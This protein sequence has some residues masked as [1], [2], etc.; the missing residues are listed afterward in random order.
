MENRDS[1][2]QD[3]YL[4]WTEAYIFSMFPICDD[5]SF[6]L[7]ASGDQ[8]EILRAGY[9]PSYNVP[10][11]EEV[12]PTKRRSYNWL[13]FTL[14][15]TVEIICL[16]PRQWLLVCSQAH[17]WLLHL[18]LPLPI[19]HRDTSQGDFKC[20]FKGGMEK[21]GGGGGTVFLNHLCWG[22]RL[23]L[24]LLLYANQ[25]LL[26]V[27][28]LLWIQYVNYMKISHLVY[29]RD[30]SFLISSVNINCFPLTIVLSLA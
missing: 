23:P 16:M 15:F 4:W 24:L 26:N 11:Y 9:W 14:P 8:T 25:D 13:K 17:S 20:P 18:P 7:V 22:A 10:F 2:A 28:G 30:T 5:L 21:G 1:K 29:T 6:R 12:S 19:P 27:W 3:S